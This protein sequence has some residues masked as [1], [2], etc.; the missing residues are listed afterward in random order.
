MNKR[1]VPFQY[2]GVID[3]PKSK[4]YLQRAIA[5]A[6]LCEGTS[7]II[8]YTESNDAIAATGIARSFGASVVVDDNEVT[9]V[10]NRKVNSTKVEINCLEAGL[11]T[12][13]FSPV[14]AALFNNVVVNGEG[15]ILTRPM[16]MVIDAL[17][18]LGAKVTSNGGFLPLQITEGIKANEITIDGSESSQLLTG[19]LVALPVLNG[20]SV[21]N[22]KNL[23]SI[24]YVQMTL[25]ILQEYGV[26]IENND[27]KIFT[28]KGNQQPKCKEYIVEGDW[29]GASFHLVGAAISGEVLVK[30]LNPKSAQADIAILEALRLCGAKVEIVNEGVFVRKNELNA[31]EFDATDCPDLFPPL[32]SLAAC[33]EGVSVIKGV[34]RLKY[35]ESDRALT[36]Q[37]EFRKLGIVVHLDGN[38][39]RVTGG[40]VS[41]GLVSSRND[42]RI[43]MATAI[44]AS[45]TNEVIE[46]TD[47]E[48]VNKSYPDFY[49]DL[50]SVSSEV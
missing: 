21:I 17:K 4:S 49:I 42:H 35:K 29:S 11:S 27:F 6:S 47:A 25:D 16:D 9:I 39:M 33:C 48:A 28:I 1:I 7:K 41:G 45:V 26:E 31:F 44:L 3:A 46:I 14:A 24:P 22:V 12:R 36:I 2:K 32:A 50:E 15:S 19:L 30:G 8:G 20:N 13:M 38:E 23:K 10:S 5:I 34:E 37:E 40:K 18:Q 43:A